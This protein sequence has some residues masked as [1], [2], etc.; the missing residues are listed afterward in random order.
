MNQWWYPSSCTC[1]LHNCLLDFSDGIYGD[2]DNGAAGG[3]VFLDLMNAFDSVHHIIFLCMLRNLVVFVE[4]T[5]RF[6][7]YLSGRS[8][9]TKVNDNLSD[10]T[11]V[12]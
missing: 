12:L 10:E 7:S 4:A 3:V 6:K 9:M 8:Q 11:G 5:E 1:L 2:I